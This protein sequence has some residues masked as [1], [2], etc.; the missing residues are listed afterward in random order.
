MLMMESAVPT[1]CLRCCQASRAHGNEPWAVAGRP[2]PLTA[3]RTDACHLLRLPGHQ[4]ASRVWMTLWQP[5]PGPSGSICFSLLTDEEMEPPR[6]VRY[7]PAAPLFW[8][9]RQSCS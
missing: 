7:L 1:N 4:L 5:H 8:L 9:R 3:A 6:E 2:L